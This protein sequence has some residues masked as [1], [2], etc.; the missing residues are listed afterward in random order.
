MTEFT[1]KLSHRFSINFSD[2]F[3]PPSKYIA[4]TI[5][6]RLSLTILSADLSIFFCEVPK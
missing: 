1:I 6:S 3:I 4:P 2:D 5:A